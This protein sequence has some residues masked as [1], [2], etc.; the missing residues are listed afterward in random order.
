PLFR[1]GIRTFDRCSACQLVFQRNHGDTLMFMMITDRIPLLLAIGILYFG[2]RPATWT[3]TAAFALALAVPLI[4]TIRE[5]QGVALALDYI[6]SVRARKTT[7]D[8][9]SVLVG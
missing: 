2:L 4:A 7:D 1:R 8:D 9:T 6:I 5:R 3:T